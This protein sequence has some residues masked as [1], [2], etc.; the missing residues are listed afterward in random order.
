MVPEDGAKRCAAVARHL[1]RQ[2]EWCRKLGS[3][4]YAT[5]LSRAA[6]DCER[7]GVVWTILEGQEREPFEAAVALRFM[8]AVHRLVLTGDAPA[9]AR[10]YPSAG[11]GGDLEEAWRAFDDTLVA[12][13]ERLRG[14]SRLPVQT[15]E[16]GRSAVLFG[17]FLVVARRTGLPLRVLELGAAAG[18]NLRWDRYLY[19]TSDATWG[20]ARSPVRF[21][22]VFEAAHPPFDTHVEVVERA[23]CD[24]LPLDPTSDEGRTTLR[25]YLWADQLERLARLEGALRVAASLPAQ[26]E[27]IAAGDWLA[28]VHTRRSEG[29]ATVIF[30]SIM[31]Q[32]VSTAERRRIVELIRAAGNGADARAP[33]AWLR[34]EPAKDDS[35]SWMYRVDLTLWPGGEETVLAKSSPHGPPVTWLAAREPAKS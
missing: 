7:G 5:L 16:V 8:G 9:L 10:H 12:H 4:L 14:L 6:V 29:T 17:G 28:R 21:A 32:Y 3:P 11:G 30:H 31:M 33:V 25:A 13:A 19:E 24:L 27:A 2:A 34:F 26:V 35:G 18:L 15:N 22:S 20:D 23:G 1:S